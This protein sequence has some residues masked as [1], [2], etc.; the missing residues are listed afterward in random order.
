MALSQSEAVTW[1]QAVIDE[2]LARPITHEDLSE[3]THSD[4]TSGDIV[5]LTSAQARGYTITW[6]VDD[7]QPV[8]G[9]KAVT[10][11][12]SWQSKGMDRRV[13]LMSVK[14]QI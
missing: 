4:A 12:V 3:G 13:V 5:P 6:D 14:P 10:A 7:D 9:A 2:V 1:G 11:T 8:A